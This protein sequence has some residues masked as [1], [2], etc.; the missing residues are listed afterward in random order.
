MRARRDAAVKDRDNVYTTYLISPWTKRLLPILAGRVSPD[1]MTLISILLAF[2]AGW[3]F[4]VG[5]TGAIVGG[6]LVYQ[7]SFA[8]DCLDGQ[9]ARYTMRSTTFG[10]LLDW[11]FDRVKETAVIAGMASGAGGEW[12][13]AAA[14]LGALAARSAITVAYQTMR[15]ARTAPA[16]PTSWGW[17]RQLRSALLLPYG[18]RHLVLAVLAI[19]VGLRTALIVL[20]YWNLYAA[21][22]QLVGRLGRRS[23]GWYHSARGDLHGDGVL[24]HRLGRL[25]RLSFPALVGFLIVA[26]PLGI[27]AGDTWQPAHALLGLGLL[28]TARLVPPWTGPVTTLLFEL[29]TIALLA[30]ADTDPELVFAAVAA[31]TLLRHF[32][33]SDVLT[34]GASRGWRSEPLGWE[35]RS[36]AWLAAAFETA[37][38]AIVIVGYTAAAALV[39][40]VSDLV[41]RRRR[42]HR[43]AAPDR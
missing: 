28:L 9:L 40:T 30:R 39:R 16:P 42:D 27:P 10:A 22:L 6:A 14:L 4:S 23:A 1:A 3:L 7:L 19:A 21:A 37:D 18:D 38:I 8:A 12:L 41:A 26:I 24:A 36:A 31:V 34:D 43:A 32:V 17:A 25:W 29:G 11:Q 2:G 15:P 33:T 13:Y 5:T 20:L 35:L